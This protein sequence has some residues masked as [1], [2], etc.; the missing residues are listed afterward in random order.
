M[1]GHV[2]QHVGT[3]V[4]TRFPY[5]DFLRKE[6][7]GEGPEDVGGDFKER[8]PDEFTLEDKGVGYVEAC[9]MDDSVAVEENVDV[10]GAVLVSPFRWAGRRLL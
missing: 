2:Y 6:L 9:G 7:L 3:R 4:S 5:L 1:L 8:A 10:D